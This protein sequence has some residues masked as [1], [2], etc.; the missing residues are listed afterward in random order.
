MTTA[1]GKSNRLKLDGT[2]KELCKEAEMVLHGIKITA[3]KHAVGLGDML[4]RVIVQDVVKSEVDY[5]L[6]DA[7]GL[8]KNKEE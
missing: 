2:L 5:T 1:D 4:V 8:V 6:F 3:D 7:T